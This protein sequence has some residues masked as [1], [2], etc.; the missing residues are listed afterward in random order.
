MSYQRQGNLK[1]K[2]RKRTS[3]KS[4]WDPDKEMSIAV[5]TGKSRIG[6]KETIRELAM[7]ELI[8]LVL[9]RNAP[10]DVVDR[11]SLLNKCLETPIPV[12]VSQNSS[13]D[14]GA[15]LGKPFWVS[16]LGIMAEGDSSILQTVEKV[17]EQQNV[18]TKRSGIIMEGN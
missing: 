10:K 9:A 14:L 11:V 15:V 7:G 3:A 4:L 8:L 16:C 1:K 13:W 2:R 6:F 17:Q 18:T 5:K 12:F